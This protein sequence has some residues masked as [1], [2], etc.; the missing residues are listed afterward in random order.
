ME[1]GKCPICGEDNHCAIVKGQDPLSCWCMTTKVPKALLE[2]VPAE[3]RRQS[4]VCKKCV[5]E[6]HQE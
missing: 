2:T 5:D 6:F 3:S 4:C 1:K